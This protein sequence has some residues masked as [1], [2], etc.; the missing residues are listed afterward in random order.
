MKKMSSNDDGFLSARM[1]RIL[2]DSR[3]YRQN[4]T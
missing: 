2:S 4:F 3:D 1:K